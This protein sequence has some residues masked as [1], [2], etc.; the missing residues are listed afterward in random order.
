MRRSACLA[1]LGLL[2]SPGALAAGSGSV[3]PALHGEWVP[4][5]AACGSALKVVIAPNKVTFFNGAQ[6][7]TYTKLDQCHTCGGR[8][9]QDVVWL[10]TDAMGDSPFIIHFDTKKRI[11]TE[12][13]F[14]ND[15]KLAARFPLKAPLKR[16]GS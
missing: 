8:D 4:A 13:D 7:Q 10:S 5:K 9:A 2:A 6:Q 14:S 15:K 12:V 1:A 3:V 11:A 16:C